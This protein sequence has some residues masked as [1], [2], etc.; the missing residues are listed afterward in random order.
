MQLTDR[1]FLAVQAADGNWA[2]L[3]ALVRSLASRIQDKAPIVRVRAIVCLSD[4]LNS[5]REG[6]GPPGEL[7]TIEREFEGRC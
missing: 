5:V 4:M 7:P 2:A 1:G 6:Q 3:V